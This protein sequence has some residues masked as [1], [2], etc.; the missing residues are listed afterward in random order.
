MPVSRTLVARTSASF[1]PLRTMVESP[2]AVGSQASRTEVGVVSLTRS[3][4]KTAAGEGEG[5]F[6]GDG[7]DDGDG[8]G[9]GS[10]P[11]VLIRNWLSATFQ[12][13]DRYVPGLGLVL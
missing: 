6:A 5:D 10:S 9:A 12:W 7:D 11:L 2:P 4:F 8:A 1:C 13:F 3:S